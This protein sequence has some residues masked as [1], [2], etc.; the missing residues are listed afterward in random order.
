MVSRHMNLKRIAHRSLEEL[1]A[2]KEIAK[3]IS[4]GGAVDTFLAK[5]DIQASV[6]NG[7]KESS[8]TRERLVKKHKVMLEYFEKT[9]AEF[10][11][12]YDYDRPLFE[13]DP[14][15]HNRIWMCWWQGLDN[16]PDIVKRCVES[17]QRNAGGHR[18]TVITEDN[19]KEYVHIPKWFEEK[20]NS[21]VISYTHFADL[22]RISLLAEHGGMWLDATFFC[23]NSNIVEYLNQPVWSIKR[24][25]YLHLSIASGYFATYALECDYKN[26][27]VF[28]TIRDF[29]LNYWKNNDFLIDYLTLDYM[30]VLSQVKDSRIRDMF[31]KIAPNNPCCEDLYMVLGE[32]YD[33]DTWIKLK[34]NTS[35]FKLSWKQEFPKMKNGCETFYAKLL[36]ETL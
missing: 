5:L 1:R 18:L 9:F 28:A 10:L 11:K 31:K 6:R 13:D 3:V 20:K 2:T 12:H 16:A 25:N 14:R 30:I 29:F 17:V 22:L 23:T 4:L 8:A 35:L 7:F 24:P 32:P 34:R 19:Y 26:R 21:G 27:W 15:L 33:E 36:D